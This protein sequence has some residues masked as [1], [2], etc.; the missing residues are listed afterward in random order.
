MNN[1][2]RIKELEDKVDWLFNTIKYG[3]DT[4]KDIYNNLETVEHHTQVETRKKK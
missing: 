1:E 3:R 4:L 2:E